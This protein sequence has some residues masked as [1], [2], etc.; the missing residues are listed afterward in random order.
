MIIEFLLPPELSIGL[1]CFIFEFE[2]EFLSSLDSN[3][4]FWE[5]LIMELIDSSSEEHSFA[6]IISLPLF[7]LLIFFLLFQMIYYIYLLYH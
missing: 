5:L 6:I 7:E 1:A 2:F 3:D 4:S